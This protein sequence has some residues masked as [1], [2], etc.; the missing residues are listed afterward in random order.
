MK[1]TMVCTGEEDSGKGI[2]RTRG[3]RTRGYRT[4]GNGTG[5]TAVRKNR[6]V[7]NGTEKKCARGIVE[8]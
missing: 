7:V 4:A 1:D 6:T 8:R 3:Y 2:Y 5:V